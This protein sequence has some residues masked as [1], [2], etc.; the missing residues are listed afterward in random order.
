MLP[1]VNKLCWGSPRHQAEFYHRDALR[2][3]K[4]AGGAVAELQ[5]AGAAVAATAATL[6]DALLVRVERKRLYDLPDFEQRQAAHQVGGA[7]RSRAGRLEQHRNQEGEGGAGGS[8][9][10]ELLQ[11]QLHPIPLLQQAAV[12]ARMGEA[13]AALRASLVSLYSRFA[14]DGEEVQAEWL[15]WLR[16][17]DAAVLEALTACVRRSLGEVAHALQGS[18]CSAEV[19]PV[20]VVS[21]IL[22]TNGRHALLLLEGR[23]ACY[24]RGAPCE[25]GLQQRQ[26]RV[27]SISSP[28]QVG[29]DGAAYS[30]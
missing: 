12:S 21:T 25:F 17:A 16:R 10:V 30:P 9:C 4:E 3:C 14:S 5:A 26:S 19:S 29:V 22:D 15:A 13:Y 8:G 2:C 6:R 23:G 18:H 27:G 28:S 11:A 7:G 1:G 24:R 20:F